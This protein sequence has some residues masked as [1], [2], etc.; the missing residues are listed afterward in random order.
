[1]RVL[2]AVLLLARFCLGVGGAS[3]LTEGGKQRC[4]PR[5]QGVEKGVSEQAERLRPAAGAGE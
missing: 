4:K 1:M 2:N 5:P 3:E